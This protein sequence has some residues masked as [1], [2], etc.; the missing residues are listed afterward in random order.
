MLRATMSTLPS[1]RAGSRWAAVITFSSTLFGSPKM[2]CET[3]RSIS[4]SKPSMRPETGLR[5]PSSRVSAETPA[6]RRP[7]SWIFFMVLPDGMSPGVG[8]EAGGA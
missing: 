1:L 2:A 3:P 5:A 7:R 8:I 6:M 4:M